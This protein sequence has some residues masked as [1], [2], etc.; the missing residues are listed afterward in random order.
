MPKP[1]VREQIVSTSL[2]L[3]HSRG[4]NATSVQDITEA[5]GVPKGSFYN[6]FASKEA[7]GLEVLERYAQLGVDSRAVLADVAVPP[8]ERLRRYFE[9]LVNIGVDSNFSCGCLLGNFG[10]ELSGQSTVIR[11]QVDLAFQEWSEVL[12]AVIAEAQQQ[13]SVA[14]DVPAYELAAFIVNAWEG[15]ALRS[16]AS[17]ERSPLDGFMN[18]TLRKVLS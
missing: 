12:A 8:L 11:Q 5:A 9:W 15:A 6:H 10:T 3:L 16:K 1:N 18:V 2:A 13:G 4:F 7:L 14:S 17:L